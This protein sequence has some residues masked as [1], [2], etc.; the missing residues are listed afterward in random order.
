V[1]ETR[2][3]ELHRP[4]ADILLE[5]NRLAECGVKEVV[6]LGQIVNFYGIRKIK[7]NC[8]QSP[9][10][11]LLRKIHC[12]N[13]IERI[14]FMSPHPCG[15]HDD[16]LRCFAELPKL[17]QCIHLPIQ[18]GSNRILKA[19]G[20]CYTRE[21]V[22]NLLL[23]IRAQNPFM[24]ISTD[25][26]VGFPGEEDVD[27]EETERL[28]SEID[29][30]MAYVFKFSPREG[31]PAATFQKQIP[32]HIAAERNKRL[33]QLLSVTSLRRHNM[34][35]GLTQ[36]VLVERSSQKNEGIFIGHNHFGKKVFFPA[37]RERIGQIIDVK[38]ISAS[39]ASLK[40]STT[41]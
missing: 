6:L 4:I 39:T 38:I 33:L 22:L 9:F 25:I 23:R 15:F 1:P 8:G 21:K 5:V 29:F 2:G 11:Q 17:C 24:S 40:G 16:L 28:F 13:G 18:S 14:R 19:M 36:P 10:V 26:I 35:I 31:T 20:R 34:F 3:R 30:D 41:Q 12:I 37:S 7:F 27:F 32:K